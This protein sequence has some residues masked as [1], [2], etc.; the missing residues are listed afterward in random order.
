MAECTEK[1]PKKRRLLRQSSRGCGGAV[2]ELAQSIIEGK[3]VLLVTGAGLSVASGI[4]PFRSRPNPLERSASKN[5]LQEGLWNDVIW[6]T[7]TRE[8]FRKDPLKWY[9][10]FWLPSFAGSNVFHGPNEAH[11]AIEELLDR[12]PNLLQITQNV[13]GLQSPRQ[14]SDSSEGQEGDRRET[15]LIEAHG[16]VGLYK[17]LPD[18]DSDTDSDSDDCDDRPVHIGHRR[19][20]RLSR[21]R[22]KDPRRCPYQFLESLESSQL[23]PDET[24]AVLM[25]YDVKGTTRSQVKSSIPETPRCPFCL[26]VVM[27]QALLFDEGYHSHAYYDFERIEDWLRDCEVF[28]FCGTSFAVRMTQVALQHARDHSIPVYN[29]NLY[30]T[31]E[32]TARLNV[33]NVTGEAHET[34]PKLLVACEQVEE[35]RKEE[36]EEGEESAD[37]SNSR[38]RRKRR[39]SPRLKGGIR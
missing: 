29:F 21:Q 24:R 2:K 28:V 39:S 19:K 33:T 11:F 31:L 9:N 25:E 10:D 17:C 32:A 16:R 22:L 12:Y 1:Q 35:E 18:H 20:S 3:R 8:T 37:V 34:I 38:T 15:Q 36:E 23:E 27:P 5:G 6:S 30:D 4:R 13:D 14:G 26:N 7:A